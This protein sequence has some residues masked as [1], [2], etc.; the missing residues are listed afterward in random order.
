MLK[1]LRTHPDRGYIRSIKHLLGRIGLRP[2]IFIKEMRYVV[3]K[4]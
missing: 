4:Y 3:G 1:A 2:A